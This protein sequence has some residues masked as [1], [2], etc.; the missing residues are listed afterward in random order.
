M[1]KAQAILGSAS[2]LILAPGVIVGVVPWLIS[3]WRMQPAIFGLPAIRGLGVVLILLGI[4]VLLE[5]FV[6]FALD[7]LG[8]PAPIFPTQ[9]LVIRGPYR[10]VRNPM[11]IAAEAVVLGQGLLLGSWIIVAYVLLVW[12]VAHMFVL[13][14]EEPTLRKTFGGDYDAY[15]ASVPRWIPRWPARDQG[16]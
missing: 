13:L 6:R 5:S 15:C 8:T 10:Y 4:P 1:R 16:Q 14:Y 2:F 11:Y 12:L 3:H 9:H 7:G